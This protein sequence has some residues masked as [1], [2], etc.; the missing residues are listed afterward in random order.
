MYDQSRILQAQGAQTGLGKDIPSPRPVTPLQ[1]RLNDLNDATGG[2]E[3]AID[4]LFRRF[5]H[6]I[7]Q[8]PPATTG[9]GQTNTPEPMKSEVSLRM[10]DSI[11]RLRRC[12]QAVDV[13]MERVE[14]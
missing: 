4:R 1:S 5:E 11:A 6:L 14:A 8:L 10:D 2:M 3:E 9:A 12:I 13:L 7:P